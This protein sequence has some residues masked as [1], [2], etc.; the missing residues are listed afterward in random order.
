M[1]V[2]SGS[3]SDSVAETPVPAVYVKPHDPKNWGTVIEA[4]E[5]VVHGKCGTARRI[6][7]GLKYRMAGKTGTAQVFTIGQK[8]KYDAKKLAKKLL[9]HALF[10]AF[11]PIENPRIA[12]AVVV[13]HGGSG[14]RTAA[15]VARK[16]LDY[17]LEPKVSPKNKSAIKL[18]TLPST[19]L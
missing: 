5:T 8:E 14:S 18:T 13:E 2:G 10:I 1:R 15:P 3:Q 4:M 6:G 7:I 19:I 17:Y 9:D 16:V 12:V 11:A